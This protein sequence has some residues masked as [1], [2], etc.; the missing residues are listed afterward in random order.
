MM[1][2]FVRQ[3]FMRDRK[4]DKCK[5]ICVVK[6]EEMTQLLRKDMWMILFMIDYFL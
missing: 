3:V 5:G 4:T 6:K 2:V 1:F